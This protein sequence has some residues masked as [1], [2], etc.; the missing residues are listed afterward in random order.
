MERPSKL[1]IRWRCSGISQIAKKYVWECLSMTLRFAGVSKEIL[2][3]L[4]HHLKAS[5]V[6]LNLIVCVCFIRIFIN[7]GQSILWT[8]YHKHGKICWAKLSLFLRVLSKFSHEYLAIVK[9]NNEHCW[10]SHHESTP[11]KNFIRLK[12]RMFSPANLSRFTCSIM[13]VHAW[14]LNYS[15]YGLVTLQSY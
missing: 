8:S 15:V 7:F 1:W 3:I 2:M 6:I 12:P 14:S 4:R 10:P 11:L 13:M 9:L 5:R